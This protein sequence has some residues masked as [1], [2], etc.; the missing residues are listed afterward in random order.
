[1]KLDNKLTQIG[2]DRTKGAAIT[3]LLSKDYPKN[4][5]NVC[6]LGR[7]IQQSHYA[8]KRID[9]QTG[10]QSPAW[11]PWSWNPIQG[12]GVGSWARVRK[13]RIKADQI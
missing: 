11:S 12:G 10:G 5:V 1:M 6:D 13:V 3:W 8:G 2:V 9:R 4:M 7:L